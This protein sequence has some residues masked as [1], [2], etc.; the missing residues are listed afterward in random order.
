MSQY[1]EP[2]V[3]KPQEILPNRWITL[4]EQRQWCE[5]LAKLNLNEPK[6]DW[7]ASQYEKYQCSVND[8][9]IKKVRYL[10]CGKRGLC[11][12]CSMSYAR[13]RASIM[14]KWIKDNIATRLDFD[15]KM[16]Q[17]V[18]TLPKELHDMDQKLFAKMIKQF[19]KSFD[20]DSYGY[21][22]QNRHSKDP[23]SGKYVHAHL[24]SLNMKQEDNQMIKS[25]YFFDLDL[26]RDTWKD[27]VQDEC[28]IKFDGK[29]NLFSEYASVLNQPAK[30][31]HNLAYL[32]RYPIQDVFNAQVRTSSTN[33]VQENAI[34]KNV[35]SKVRDLLEEKKPRLVWCGMLTSAKRKELIKTMLHLQYQTT[36]DE[37]PMSPSTILHF[38]QPEYYWKSMKDVEKEIE[39]RSKECRDCG[40]PYDTVPYETGKYDGNNEPVIFKYA[41]VG[42]SQ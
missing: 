6:L 41:K 36:I 33:Y 25:E 10:N 40:S 12:R 37:T 35:E 29:V 26:M 31:L 21:S 23:L 13:M 9:H 11:P 15:L 14:Y 7:C 39:I 27:I 1:C 3:E 38:D 42:L 16:N 17:I 18:L 28:N 32:Y 2:L 20:L 30:V 19:M 5:F 24:L 22:I 8:S 4:E 34:R